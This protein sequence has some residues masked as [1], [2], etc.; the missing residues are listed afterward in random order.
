M[1]YSELDSVLEEEETDA[2]KEG[3]TDA[4]KEEEQSE[5]LS[6]AVQS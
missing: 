5:V 4:E 3:E 6:S 1:P 2:D